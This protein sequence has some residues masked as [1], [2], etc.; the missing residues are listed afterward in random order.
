MGKDRKITRRRVDNKNVF[1]MFKTAS[2][3]T[4]LSFFTMGAGQLLRKQYAKGI[5]YLA[6]QILFTLFL[7]FFGGRYIAQ[8]FSGNLGTRLAGEI[9]N[10]ELQIFEK[11]QG[12]N[13]FLILLYGVASIVLC[14]LYA[15]VWAMNIKGSYQNDLRIKNGESVRSFKEDFRVF[16]NEKFHIPLLSLPFL[17]L[18]IFTVMPLIFMVLIAFTNYD[19]AHTLPGKLFDWVGFTNFKTF[20]SF[21]NGSSGD[22]LHPSG[23]KSPRKMSLQAVTFTPHF[24]RIRL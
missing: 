17:G 7:V 16:I 8:L 3:P 19:Y 20:F 22:K 6:T 18:V 2:F 11:V 15:L 24:L 13:S 14:V 23:G 4:K 10:E 5:L 12:D 21:S 9:W 1:A